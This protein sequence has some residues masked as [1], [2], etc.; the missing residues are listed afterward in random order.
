[1]HYKVRSCQHLGVSEW[2]GRPTK[3]GLPTAVTQHIKDNKCDCSF[4]DFSIIGREADYHLRHIKESL[5]IK[6]YDYEL[7][8]QSTS[9]ELFLF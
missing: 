6:L 2:T 4:D 7:N 5:F 3:G 1:M 9:T 8:K